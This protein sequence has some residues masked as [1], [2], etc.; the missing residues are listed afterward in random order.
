M[1]TN[2]ITNINL[3][4]GS[5]ADPMKRNHDNRTHRLSKNGPMIVDIAHN[6][7]LRLNT[8]GCN[9]NDTDE[10]RF[11]REMNTNM[12]SQIRSTVSESHQPFY[13]RTK[14]LYD[15]KA[16]KR[17][18]K[19]SQSQDESFSEQLKKP[20]SVFFHFTCS[21][22]FGFGCC[23]WIQCGDFR[24]G[25]NGFAETET[26]THWEWRREKKTLLKIRIFVVVN[27]ERAWRKH[28]YIKNGENISD[29]LAC[30]P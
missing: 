23:R 1:K 17:G 10:T 25:K 22:C 3:L 24:V 13:W 14:S 28:G 9:R 12:A 8:G 30:F 27:N 29:I 5:H 18:N 26:N 6:Y 21:H 2:R 15:W 11:A 20:D 16:N 19:K 4:A 7:W